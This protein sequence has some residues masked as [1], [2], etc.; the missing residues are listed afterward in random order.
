MPDRP[1][2]L[3]Y[4]DANILIYGLEADDA[5]GEWARC[6]LLQIQ[7]RQIVAVTSEMTFGEA[8]PRPLAEG[9]M[10]I[11]NAYRALLHSDGFL[12]SPVTRPI[13]LAAAEL[14]ARRRLRLPDAIHVATAMAEQCAAFLSNDSAVL[15]AAPMR[16]LS[17][18]DLELSL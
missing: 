14:R 4:L 9:E 16:S 2:P 7:K 12:L 17:R 13:I 5:L 3:V 11:A 15:A 8:L 1:A 10:T 18:T 6:W